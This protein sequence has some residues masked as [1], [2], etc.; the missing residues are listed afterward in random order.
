MWDFSKKLLPIMVYNS[1]M[2]VSVEPT[3]VYLYWNLHNL[4]PSDLL[5]KMRDFD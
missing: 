1:R 2:L 5:P 3:T 4:L